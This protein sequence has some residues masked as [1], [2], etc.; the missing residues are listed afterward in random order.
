MKDF[1]VL[2]CSITQVGDMH[3]LHSAERPDNERA[4]QKYLRRLQTCFFRWMSNL[5]LLSCRT[6][7]INDIFVSD[8]LDFGANLPPHFVT[9]R[10][11]GSGRLNSDILKQ[12]QADLAPVTFADCLRLSLTTLP[13]TLPGIQGSVWKNMAGSSKNKFMNSVNHPKRSRW[14]WLKTS[15]MA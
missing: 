6:L 10:A 12:F 5:N 13:S 11:S 4:M 8:A 2:G 1:L 3:S 14:L 15:M 9:Y 7:P